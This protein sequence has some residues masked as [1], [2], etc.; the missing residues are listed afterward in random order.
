MAGAF[1]LVVLLGAA[2]GGVV[3]WMF[4]R[5][6]VSA[7]R[8]LMVVCGFFVVLLAGE[9]VYWNTHGRHV[10]LTS[11]IIGWSLALFAASRAHAAVSRLNRID[12]GDV[13]PVFD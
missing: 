10:P 7:A 2:F 1:A 11:Q 9:A 3:L 5:R 8:L 12:L 4:L 6:S 13:A